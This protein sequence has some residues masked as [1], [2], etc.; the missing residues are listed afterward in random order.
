MFRSGRPLLANCERALLEELSNISI[1]R[2][3]NAISVYNVIEAILQDPKVESVFCEGSFVMYA[4]NKLCKNHSENRLI[5]PGDIDL[6]IDYHGSWYDFTGA[7]DHR[8][9]QS[10]IADLSDRKKSIMSERRDMDFQESQLH[11]RDEL[12]EI[13][14]DIRRLTTQNI[15]DINTPIT[16]LL[17]LKSH[18][19]EVKPFNIAPQQSVKAMTE[20]ESQ[21]I[22]KIPL[23]KILDLYNPTLHVKPVDTGSHRTINLAT[24]VEFPL[25]HRGTLQWKRGPSLELTITNIDAKAEYQDDMKPGYV[26]ENIPK[27]FFTLDENGLH[28]TGENLYD[29]Y[30]DISLSASERGV[31]SCASLV[32]A[33]E[34]YLR[35]MVIPEGKTYSEHVPIDPIRSA[36]MFHKLKCIQDIPND[37]DA[38]EKGA[39]DEGELNEFICGILKKIGNKHYSSY[40][41]IQKMLMLLKESLHHLAK[42]NFD[43]KEGDIEGK[44]N[45]YL[46]ACMIQCLT[47]GIYGRFNELEGKILKRLN[48]IKLSIS[49]RLTPS[50]AKDIHDSYEKYNREL[51]G[52]PDKITNLI[53]TTFRITR[54]PELTGI[55]NDVM[56]RIQE[57]HEEAKRN[58]Q[59]SIERHTS[60]HDRPGA[61]GKKRTKRRH[62]AKHKS[63]KHTKEKHKSKKSKKNKKNKK[64]KTKHKHH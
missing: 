5:K 15:Q 48:E 36:L 42:R 60:T 19:L 21:E 16:Q 57:L 24:T 22:R 38:W 53:S 13:A 41:T 11:R 28:I 31:T 4:F 40:E 46:I 17:D 7:R 29:N 35:Y 43:Y 56:R 25:L 34:I 49:S 12:N 10:R 59:D 2:M 61:R 58:A 20:I 3:G 44:L 6:H 52:I 26:V 39:N 14:N 54:T 50:N 9:T 30:T 47:R 37:I 63:K 51:M 33:Y 23:R 32:K 55:S 64:N 45:P 62:R 18:D 8:E 1:E 27:L